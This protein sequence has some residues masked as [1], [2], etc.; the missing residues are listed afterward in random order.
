MDWYKYIK[1]YKT[2]TYSPARFM[3]FPVIFHP[4]TMVHSAPDDVKEMIRRYHPKGE[5]SPTVQQWDE[6]MMKW[7]KD[8]H[9]SKTAPEKKKKKKYVS[10]LLH[11]K[12][13][14]C[15]VCGDIM[16]LAPCAEE[17]THYE[18]MERADAKKMRQCLSCDEYNVP[19]DSRPGT[20]CEYCNDQRPHMQAYIP[21]P[22]CEYCG[23]YDVD[24]PCEACAPRVARGDTRVCGHCGKVRIMDGDYWACAVCQMDFA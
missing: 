4:W 5:G 9:S 20:E 16:S 18:C 14:R 10:S 24:S 3:E 8:A 2:V 13:T 1:R 11:I 22:M 21:I 7:K 15:T 12:P 17:L 6:Y 19:A 23:D